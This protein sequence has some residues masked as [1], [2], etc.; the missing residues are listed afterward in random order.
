MMILGWTN[1]VS[2]HRK[3]IKLGRMTTLNVVFHEMMS[4]YKLLKTWKLT[5]VPCAISEWPEILKS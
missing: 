3:S 5:P 2:V 4:V 1:L